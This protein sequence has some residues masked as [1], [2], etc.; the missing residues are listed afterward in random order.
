MDRTTEATI[1][2]HWFPELLANFLE[3]IKKNH[4]HVIFTTVLAPQLCM[5]KVLSAGHHFF[6]GSGFP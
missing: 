6:S 1:D 5:G 2:A 3:T 4:A